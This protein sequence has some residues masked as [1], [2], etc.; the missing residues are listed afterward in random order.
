MRV[1]F[2][3]AADRT[4]ATARYHGWLVADYLKRS[5]VAARMLATP[6]FPY[7]ESPWSP[8]LHAD[9][10]RL[11][12]GEVVVFQ[13][14]RGRHA[15]ALAEAL[16]DAHSRT[17]AVYGD[18]DPDNDLA[19]RCDVLVCSSRWLA[20][21]YA[22]RGVERVIAIPDP[23][24]F[25]A[26]RD[27]IDGGPSEAGLIRLVWMGHRGNWETLEP[28]RELL[29]EPAL[30]DF[31]LIT[32]SNH[33]D[34]DVRWSP[35]SVRQI[36]GQ[37]HIGVVP[38]RPP[39]VSTAKSNN[40]VIQF[41]AAG[42]PLVAGRIPSYEEVVRHGWNGFLCENQDEWRSALLELRDPGR[43][44]EI[45]VRG[46][47]AVFPRY[48]VNTIG[49]EWLALFKSLGPVDRNPLTPA[50]EARLLARIR[51]AAQI[52]YAREALERNLGLREVLRIAG[53]AAAYAPIVPGGA[54]FLR[55]TAPL[56]GTRVLKKL[57]RVAGSAPPAG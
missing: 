23:A 53:P 46:F 43:R 22:D 52:T 54:A 40:R 35:E 21:H 2:I 8:A 28:L 16:R 49:A 34:A 37:G 5:S 57:A 4:I 44:R 51:G 1:N 48:H 19:F 36:V 45:G 27:A 50:Q 41:M 26:D 9:L 6:P 24:E 17:V 47:D 32:V 7:S 18:W 12:A 56:V 20:E 25:W 55:D 30:A 13:K 15:L 31:R 29:A 38:T 14:Q 33:A 3:L 42:K 11:L 39:P 10:K